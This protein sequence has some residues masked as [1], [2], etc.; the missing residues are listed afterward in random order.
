MIKIVIIDGQQADRE[1]MNAF[2]STQNDFEIVG[3]GGDGYEAIRLVENLKPDI[4]LLDINLQYLDG[5]QVISILKIRSP[6]TSIII[7]TTIDD[8]EYVFKAICNGT[9]GYLLK[10]TNMEDTLAEGIRTVYNGGSLMTPK[11]AT[12]AFRIFS[13]L[14]KEKNI[15]HYFYQFQEELTPKLPPISQTEFK[16]T[17]CIGQGLSNKEIAGI[18]HLREGTIRNYISS[19]L[20][21]TG[22]RDRTQVAIY[23]VRN[24]LINHLEKSLRVK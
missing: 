14:V 9:S 4:A 20:Q 23:A 3:I 15:L 12:K 2:L 21:K 7:L 19:I 24:G 1:R 16:I 8:D 6:D 5:V 13:T 11:I 18:L 22:L 10:T 17:A